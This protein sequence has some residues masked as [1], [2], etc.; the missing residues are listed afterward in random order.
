VKGEYTLKYLAAKVIE[1]ILNDKEISE[2]LAGEL[3]TYPIIDYIRAEV[4]GSHFE[5]IENFINSASS[6]EVRRLGISILNNLIKDEKYARKIKDFL[7]S[8]WRN[9]DNETKLYI[10][11]KLLDFSDLENTFHLEL[12]EF[13][14]ENWKAW[15]QK[16]VD[17]CGGKDKVL[18]VVTKRLQDPS[19]PETIN[20]IKIKQ[21]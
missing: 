18:D 21:T 20:R 13:V 15:L 9:S 19:F 17:W 7:C 10:M 12:Y 2:D 11:W 5:R 3:N 6:I 1:D 8:L 16:A 4:R 14:K